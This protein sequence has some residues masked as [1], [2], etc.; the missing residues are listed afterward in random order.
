M[1]RDATLYPIIEFDVIAQA[2][3]N[4]GWNHPF[5]K[6]IKFFFSL[7]CDADSARFEAPIPALTDYSFEY[8][9]FHPSS[10]DQSIAQD[11]K[12]SNTTYGF[13]LKEFWTFGSLETGCPI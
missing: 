12:T 8:H 3:P 13:K 9:G 2:D 7:I 11:I 6:Q 4:T 5:T 1:R 10:F